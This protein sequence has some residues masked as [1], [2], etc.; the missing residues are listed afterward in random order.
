[1]DKKG[2]AAQGGTPREFCTITGTDGI[3][4]GHEGMRSSLP[5]PA[6]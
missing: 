6:R 5:V 4:M 3:A 1:M 2:V